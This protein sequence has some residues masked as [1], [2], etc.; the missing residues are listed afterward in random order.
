MSSLKLDRHLETKTK[1]ELKKDLSEELKRQK[2]W[3]VLTVVTAAVP[4]TSFEMP[5]APKRRITPTRDLVMPTTVESGIWPEPMP[6][7]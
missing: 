7:L 4:N 5:F 2:I 6:M 3:L 1:E